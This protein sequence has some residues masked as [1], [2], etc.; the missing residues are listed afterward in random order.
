L[1]SLQPAKILI[2]LLAELDQI[3]PKK[4]KQ[5]ETPSKYSNACFLANTEA[6]TFD[7]RNVGLNQYTEDSVAKFLFCRCS[8]SGLAPV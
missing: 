5:P 3:S 4:P 6:K 1:I 8:A 2:K 7:L